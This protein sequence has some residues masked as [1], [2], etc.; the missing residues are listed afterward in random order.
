MKFFFPVSPAAS[1]H[2]IVRCYLFILESLCVD[3]LVSRVL[4]VSR[5]RLLAAVL[6]DEVPV[7]DCGGLQAPMAANT[8]TNATKMF[9]I[10]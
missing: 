1:T 6:S 9:F 10:N 5:A 3:T 2:Y 4:V 8:I 7:V